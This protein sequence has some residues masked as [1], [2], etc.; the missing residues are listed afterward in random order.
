MHNKIDRKAFTMLELVFVIAVIGILSTIAIPRLAVTRDDAVVTK[1]R[2]TVAS[3]RSSLSMLRQKNILKGTFDDINGTALLNEMKYGL[4]S[5]WSYNGN[6]FTFQCPNPGDT[7]VF[8]INN[9]KH[10]LDKGHCS[11]SCDMAD[12]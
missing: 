6:T 4:G 11:P 9:T 10:T 7:C 12:L 2:T 1:A 5:D 3:L 8:S